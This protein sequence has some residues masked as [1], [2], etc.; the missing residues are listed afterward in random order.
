[1]WLAADT[2]FSTNLVILAGSVIGGAAAIIASLL[3]SRPRRD[4][5]EG[6]TKDAVDRPR[7]RVTHSDRLT[8]IESWKEQRV[9]PELEE[10]QGW[11]HYARPILRRVAN[12]LEWDD[13]PAGAE[14]DGSES[15]DA[16]KHPSGRRPRP[17]PPQG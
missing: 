17:R 3:A 12:L 10:I 14:E 7:R 6:S 2:A 15:P 9:D 13:N 5:G 8:R 1:M 4:S 16:A 11:I